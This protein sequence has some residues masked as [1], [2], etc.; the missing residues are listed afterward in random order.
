MERIEVEQAR[1]I[2]QNTPSEHRVNR[3]PGYPCILFFMPWGWTFPCALSSVLA[4]AL[5]LRGAACH[6]YTC[7]GG[8]PICMYTN[9]RHGPPMPCEGCSSY[10]QGLFKAFELPYST[11]KD[12][13]SCEEI[14]M[15]KA[16]VENLT[17]EQISHFEYAGLPLGR[18]VKLSVR[19]F[20]CSIKE[21]ATEQG[22]QI[23]RSFLASALVTANLCKRLFSRASPDVVVMVNG[24]FYAEQIVSC[25][26]EQCG[27]KVVTFEGGWLKDTVIFSKHAPAARCQ[28]D[29]LWNQWAT[30][31]LTAEENKR[32]DLYLNDRRQGARST[33]LYWPNIV[34]DRRRIRE[35]LGLDFRRPLVTVFPNILWDS[36]AQDC[37]VAF[38]DILDWLIKTVNYYLERPTTQLLI[39][40]HPAEVRLPPV[41]ESVE[42]IADVLR[43]QF[44]YLPSHIKIILATSSLSS[45]MIAEMSDVVAVYTSSMGLEA[46]LQGVPVIVAG[47]PHYRGKGFTFDADTQEDYFALLEQ[48]PGQELDM[49]G[50]VELARRYAYALFF[51][52]MLPF[53]LITEPIQHRPL[54]HFDSLSEL[55]PGRNPVLDLICD[56]IL[57]DSEFVLPRGM[58]EELAA[59]M[60]GETRLERQFRRKMYAEVVI[61][62]FFDAYSRRD[63]PTV[64]SALV[65]AVR[66]DP[67]WLMNRGVVS[68]TTEAFLGSSTAR[69]TRK[70]AR[71][72]IGKEAEL[73]PK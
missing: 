11:L 22:L 3:R 38:Q 53:N 50:R 42:R 73:P 30:T 67:S 24:L 62:S 9:F 66:Y 45:Y 25:L 60:S 13:M 31:P 41:F 16:T 20:L 33:D 48:L 4:H 8:L 15:A 2:M 39:R 70:L 32:L 71:R 40:V 23:Y 29:P 34:N 21:D 64:R 10:P 54:Y 68:I 63:W 36:A 65:K 27:V 56:A 47:N 58:E 49:T 61:D 26:A 72:V 59:A 52:C 28:I 12:Y 55:L 6:M 44:S 37:D 17:A 43:E 1:Q 7:G 35:E 5:R 69:F 57:H 14:E 18:I 46:A 51:R 19:W